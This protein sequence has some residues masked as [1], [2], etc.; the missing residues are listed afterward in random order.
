MKTSAA[1]ASSDP[2]VLGDEV[3]WFEPKTDGR[4]D[5]FAKTRLGP[6]FEGCETIGAG[7]AVCTLRCGT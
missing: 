5:L 6:L 2:Q 7:G 4:Y 1:G 3:I